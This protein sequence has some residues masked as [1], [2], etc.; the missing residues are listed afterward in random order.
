MTIV[1]GTLVLDANFDELGL[2]IDVAPTWRS[3]CGQ[4]CPGYDLNRGPGR[5]IATLPG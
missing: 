4:S 2:V 1:R 5:A 3:E